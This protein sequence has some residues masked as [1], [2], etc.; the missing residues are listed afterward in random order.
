MGLDFQ[1]LVEQDE[2]NIESDSRESPGSHRDL[3]PFADPD[4]SEIGAIL[5]DDEIQLGPLWKR[6][7]PDEKEG[8]VK[9]EHRERL[10][11]AGPLR[12]LAHHSAEFIP[13]DG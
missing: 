4:C 11:E 3:F 6:M 13:R 5:K 1:F 10:G 12:P 9:I 7:R 8:T 2:R